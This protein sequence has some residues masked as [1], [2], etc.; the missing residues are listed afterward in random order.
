MYYNE[1]TLKEKDA[2]EI[3]GVIAHEI[4]H[5]VRFHW[6]RCS[7]GGNEHEK[8]NAAADCEINDDITQGTK[9]QLPKD[10][11]F[12]NKYG[13]K[14]GLLAEDYFELLAN[15][16]VKLPQI[17]GSCSDGK[18][19]P[20]EQGVNDTAMS[21]QEIESIQKKVAEDISKHPGNVPGGLK[22]W[23][24]SVLK[25]KVDWNSQLR[26]L[27]IN[28]VC[29]VKGN[30]TTSFKVPPRRRHPDFILPGKVSPNPN[31]TVVIDT[32]GSMCD[33]DQKLLTQCLTET[34]SILKCVPSNCVKV[35]TGDT[36]SNFAKKVF[37]SG[38]IELIGGGGT[39]MASIMKEHE[40]C[41]IMVLLTDGYTPWP[42]QLKCRTIAC[43]FSSESAPA[44]I[45]SVNITEAI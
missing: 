31:V 45:K 30:L 15:H 33:I 27:V 28:T 16:T 26:A 9:L 37:H 2:Y 3:A 29:W 4:A 14:D 7:F 12:P 35:V 43:I 38:Q 25:P 13:F 10:G 5:L 23:A 44:W 19:R 1:E 17:G 36:Q 6:K 34:S 39:D 41:D 20:W 21:E 18:K 22:L 32:S 40:K 24:K 42:D 8:W 11:C